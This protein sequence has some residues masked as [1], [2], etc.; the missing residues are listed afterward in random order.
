MAASRDGS[1]QQSHD[2]VAQWVDEGIEFHPEVAKKV[3]STI[4]ASRSGRVSR[5]NKEEEPGRDTVRP[6]F[7]VHFINEGL[8]QTLS[9]SG[10]YLEPHLDLVSTDESELPPLTG[11]VVYQSPPRGDS[12]SDTSPERK[13]PKVTKGRQNKVCY[14]LPHSGKIILSDGSKPQVLPI[15]EA[16][17]TEEAPREK[18]KVKRARRN[19]R[20]TDSQ[21]S[22]VYNTLPTLRSPYL[23]PLTSFGKKKHRLEPLNHLAGLRY[24]QAS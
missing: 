10:L 8:S 3:S 1:P 14:L 24:C 19:K 16:K 7:R 15:I 18:K 21:H 12:Y 6:V 2:K 17:R 23:Y 22:G 11:Q 20:T 9:T 13:K 5:E 4:A